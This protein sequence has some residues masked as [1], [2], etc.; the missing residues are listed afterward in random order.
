MDVVFVAFCLAQ[1]LMVFDLLRLNRNNLFSLPVVC[2]LAVAA[3]MFGLGATQHQKVQI[4]PYPVVWAVT[5]CCLASIII[6]I[7]IVGQ[8]AKLTELDYWPLFVVF[9]AVLAFASTPVAGL[10]VA[11]AG[12]AL[13]V[14]L[15]IKLIRYVKTH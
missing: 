15:N 10:A 8:A 9:M 7:P 3:A 5:F 13:Q 6:H 2:W 1:L 11:I 14:Q 4:F 12:H